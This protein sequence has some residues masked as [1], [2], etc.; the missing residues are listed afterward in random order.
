MNS[1]FDIEQNARALSASLRTDASRRC[2]ISAADTPFSLRLR[3]RR[4]PAF[5]RARFYLGNDD[6]ILVQGAEAAV[7]WEGETALL[8]SP[9]CTLEKGLYFFHFELETENGLLYTC[10][11]TLGCTLAERFSGEWQLLVYADAPARPYDARR[12][13]PCVRGPLP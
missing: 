3:L 5:A 4:P 2:V 11:E 12:H 13:L 7:E 10:E 6:G 1:F 8:C 9:S